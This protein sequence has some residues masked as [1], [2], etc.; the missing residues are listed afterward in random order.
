[1]LSSSRGS[2][3]KTDNPI[4]KNSLESDQSLL[5]PPST[6][7]QYIIFSFDDTLNS[8]MGDGMDKVSMPSSSEE[9]LV[10][11]DDRLVENR[12]DS[13]QFYMVLPERKPQGIGVSVRETLNSS[14]NETDKVFNPSYFTVIADN[15]IAKNSM[16]SDQ[17]STAPPMTESQNIGMI[18]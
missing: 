15:P 7:S 9:S 4:D 2:P 18:G 12:L 6:N 8:A 10:I 13:N 16:D 1:M 14:S 17:S 11:A 5:A 3:V